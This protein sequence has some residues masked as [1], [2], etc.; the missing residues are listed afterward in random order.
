[1][2]CSFV[3]DWSIGATCHDLSVADWSIGATCY[4]IFLSQFGV[5]GP[6]STADW[7]IGAKS[8][9]LEKRRNSG[10]SETSLPTSHV[11]HL[12]FMHDSPTCQCVLMMQPQLGL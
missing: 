1:M 3:A 8:H 12:S 2:S 5:F 10:K 4:V 11:K 9:R 7:S 6:L